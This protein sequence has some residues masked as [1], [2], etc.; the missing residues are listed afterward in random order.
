MKSFALIFTFAAAIPL[1]GCQSFQFVDSPIPV[2]NLPANTV[3]VERASTASVP[4]SRI[5]TQT[6]ST[7]DNAQ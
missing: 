5:A 1:T 3:L 4:A 6:V 7:P 2:K